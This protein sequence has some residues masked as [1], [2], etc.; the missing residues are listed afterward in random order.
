MKY[1]IVKKNDVVFVYTITD[2]D[3]AAVSLSGATILWQLKLTSDDTALIEKTTSS[4]ISITDAAGGEFEVTLTDTDTDID[5]GEYYIE[6][7]ITDASGYKYT[8]TE[9]D[10]DVSTLEIKQNYA[11]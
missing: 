5:V 3:G 2:Q 4:G 1:T 8:V 10:F 9:D 7:L 11:E 6:A